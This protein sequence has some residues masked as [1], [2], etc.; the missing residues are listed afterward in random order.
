MTE[1]PADHSPVLFFFFRLQVFVRTQACMIFLLRIPVSV[2]RNP[3]LPAAE[4]VEPPPT[5]MLQFRQL[6]QGQGRT[7]GQDIR[8]YLLKIGGGDIG[9]L[10][11]TVQL[12]PGRIRCFSG[13]KMSIRFDVVIILGLHLRWTSASSRI[14]S[15]VYSPFPKACR[16]EKFK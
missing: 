13:C 3:I 7:G 4:G 14:F 1:H 16:P 5:Q 10:G 2:L 15:S 8:Q 11:K 6:L 9:P 12:L